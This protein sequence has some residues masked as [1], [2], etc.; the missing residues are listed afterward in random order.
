MKLENVLNWIKLNLSKIGLAVLGLLLAYTMFLYFHARH[1]SE[2]NAQQVVDAHNQI[3]QLSRTIQENENTWARL[4]QER[5]DQ[6]AQLQAQNNDLAQ[7]IQ[8]RNEQIASLTDIVANFRPIHIIAQGQA[9]TETTQN[10]RVRVDFD[11]T[12]SDYLRVAGHTLTNP[13]EAALDIQFTRPLHLTIV[14]TQTEDGAWNT[15]VQTDYED[16]Q[17]DEIDASINPRVAANSVVLQQQEHHGW[18]D[19]FQVGLF[20]GVGTSGNSGQLGLSLGYDFSSVEI[21][22]LGSGVVYSG[23]SDIIVGAEVSIHPFDL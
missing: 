14:S 2:A 12:H 10:E 4:T 9:A 5:D 15:H 6:M 21:D 13:A 22:L 20:G 16:L 8:S 19:G 3:A 17:I 23:G 18:E 1:L 11:Q 7:V